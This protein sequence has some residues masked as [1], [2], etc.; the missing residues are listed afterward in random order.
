[1]RHAVCLT[2]LQRDFDVIGANVRHFLL[3]LVGGGS[4]L[5]M[6][7]VQP[8]GES[9]WAIRRLLPLHMSEPQAPLCIPWYTNSSDVPWYHCSSRG[10]AHCERNFLQALCD[11]AQCEAMISRHERTV[12]RQ[13]DVVH[14]MRADMMFERRLSLP[15]LRNDTVYVPWMNDAL[16]I[17]DQAAFGGRWAMRRYLTRVQHVVPNLTIAAL[18]RTFNRRLNLW[19]SARIISEEFLRV[20]LHR[21][22]VKAH[23]LK[24]WVY[25][26]HTFRSYLEGSKQ[27]GCVARAR[28]RTRCASLVCPRF[29]FKHWCNCHNASC[30]VIS[31]VA[32]GGRRP[33]VANIGPGNNPAWV[34]SLSL[35][36]NTACVDVGPG[37]TIDASSSN[38][39]EEGTQLFLRTCSL[40]RDAE[41]VRRRPMF[42]RPCSGPTCAGVSSG[43]MPP[44]VYDNDPAHRP[45]LPVVMVP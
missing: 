17:N 33:L 2:G 37:S 3:D 30:R 20:V 40:R 26:L 12:G 27:R 39:G 24:E 15:T 25:C 6:F 36:A 5:T 41:D 18:Q 31:G 4:E 43:A 9:W 16:G 34:R 29:G 38:D 42:P 11:L 8:E 21:E 32:N 35:D 13:F 7:G 19:G 22:G 45:S 28:A 1:M 23:P 10:R 44:C 14:R